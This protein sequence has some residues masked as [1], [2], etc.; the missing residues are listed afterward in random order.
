MLYT[1]TAYTVK[2]YIVDPTP[3]AEM[4]CYYCGR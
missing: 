1:F 3:S 2:K 4:F